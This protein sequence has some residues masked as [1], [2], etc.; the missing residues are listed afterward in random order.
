MQIVH[1]GARSLEDYGKCCRSSRD[2][3]IGKSIVNNDRVVDT[4][5]WPKLKCHVRE[6]WVHTLMFSAPTGKNRDG[7]E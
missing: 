7:L 3:H 4:I 6:L 5:L 2:Q 1:A